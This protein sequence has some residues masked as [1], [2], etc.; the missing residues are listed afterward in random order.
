MNVDSFHDKTY[1]NWEGKSFKG[2]KGGSRGPMTCTSAHL[3]HNREVV[4]KVEE[5]FKYQELTG[6]YRSGDNLN[7]SIQ[8]NEKQKRVLEFTWD[9]FPSNAP[10]RDLDDSYE[11]YWFV[12]II[13]DVKI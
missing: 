8:I 9:T 4:D 2:I 12:P 3:N 5:A 11:T 1:K 13:K 10:S 6:Y 7:I